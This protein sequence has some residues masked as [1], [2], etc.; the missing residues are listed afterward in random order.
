M[1]IEE[2]IEAYNQ[3]VY[4]GEMPAHNKSVLRSIIE[5]ENKFFD[6]EPFREDSHTEPVEGM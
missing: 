1:T 2:E 6:K 5:K 4:K 3:K